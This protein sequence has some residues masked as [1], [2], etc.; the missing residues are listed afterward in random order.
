MGRSLATLEVGII[1]FGHVGQELVQLLHQGFGLTPRVW[2]RTPRHVDIATS[3][4]EAVEL[5][6]LIESSDVLLLCA[7]PGKDPL[8]TSELLATAKADQVVINTA[9]AELVSPRVLHDHLVARPD[10]RW[11]SDVYYT[12]PV[13]Q[14][15]DT[16]GLLALGPSRFCL[17]PH[18]AYASSAASSAM[19]QMVIENLVALQTA[20]PLPNVLADPRQH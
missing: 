4:G 3:G 15:M 19:G 18:M 12:E 17:T 10:I 1:G 8:L 14:S 7:S 20:Q 9:R 13:N 16:Y 2:N 5:T 11:L 6:E